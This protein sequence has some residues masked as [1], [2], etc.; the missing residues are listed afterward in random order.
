MNSQPR[1]FT[2]N[3]RSVARTLG[4]IGGRWT[5]LVLREAFMGSGGSTSFSATPGWPVT[6]SPCGSAS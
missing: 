2:N 4:I 5:F 6:S 3:N 1:W